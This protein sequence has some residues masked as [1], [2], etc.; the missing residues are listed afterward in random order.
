MVDLEVSEPDVV[1]VAVAFAALVSL[2]DVAE[3]QASVDIA[4]A[5][6]VLAPA[7]VVATDLDSSGRPRF[8][9]FPNGDYAASSSSSVGVVGEESVHSSIGVRTNHGFCSILSNRGLH[10][11]KKREHCY[12]TP[13]PD[14]NNVSGTSDP[15]INATTNHSRKTSLPLYQEQ[16][17]HTYQVSLS[18]LVVL[19]VGWGAAEGN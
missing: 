15:P 19:E 11:N 10:Q 8:L 18:P 14:Y 17:R 1:F 9:S 16:R 2:A 4:L 7:P 6:D 3:P 5:F 13:N 12:S